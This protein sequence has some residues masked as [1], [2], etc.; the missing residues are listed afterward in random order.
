MFILHSEVHR[1]IGQG[2]GGQQ[3]SDPRKVPKARTL[4]GRERSE[5]HYVGEFIPLP[6][7]TFSNQPVYV[8]LADDFGRVTRQ[9]LAG[10]IT[11]K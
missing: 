8:T 9:K 5:G 4:P 11:L 6:S 2:A 10:E 3:L 1:I 7:D